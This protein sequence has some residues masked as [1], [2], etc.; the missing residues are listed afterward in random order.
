VAVRVYAYVVSDGRVAVFSHADAPDA[1]LQIPGGGVEDGEDLAAAVRR[2]VLEESGL[3]CE[4]VGDLG[5]ST[6]RGWFP[7]RGIVDTHR[8]YF[9]LRPTGA[10]RETWTWYER[11]ASDGT[12]PHEL[13]FRWLPFAEAATELDFGFGAR[14]GRLDESVQRADA[15]DR[16]A[17]RVVAE[18]YEQLAATYV[19]WS[20]ASD[21]DNPRHAW[22]DRALAGRTVERA[23]DLGCGTG[24][25]ASAYLHERGCQVTAVDIST[26][27]VARG[28]ERY[29]DIEFIAADLTQLSLLGSFDLVTAFYSVIHI[30]RRQ[31]PA[32][33]RDVARWLVPGGRFVVNLE[34]SGNSGAGCT[35]P[36]LDGVPMF[37]SAWSNDESHRLLE[38]AGLRVLDEE[39]QGAGDEQFLWLLCEK[40]L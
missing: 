37:W 12:G 9:H 3:D 32:L 31:Q 4:V 25:L 5:P 16:E 6:R 27:S 14:L 24:E 8:H 19:T 35:E 34:P 38:R 21:L 36:W 20:R 10:V 29:P 13:R 11:H 28:A 18:G 39:R 40:P 7:G 22:I 1:G 15:A 30:P 2:E 23:L 26:V 33:F 17:R